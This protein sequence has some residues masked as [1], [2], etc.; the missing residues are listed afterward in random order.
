MLN[1]T[2][3]NK[4]NLSN[5][6]KFYIAALLIWIF[7]LAAG[8]F[9]P[10]LPSKGLM[11][12]ALAVSF[13]LTFIVYMNMRSIM[14]MLNEAL[15][16]NIATY[17]LK[18]ISVLIV[19]FFIYESIAKSIPFMLNSFIGEPGYENTTVTG[20]DSAV[21]NTSTRYYIDTEILSN[22]YFCL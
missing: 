19:C 6:S 9:V 22:F 13:V 21:S 16:M 4:K 2:N 12:G 3:K 5:K 1:S 15:K 8:T 18:L 11:I 14:D 7:L 20:K 10:F 17:S